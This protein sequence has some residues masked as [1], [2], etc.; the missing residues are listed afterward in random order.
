[1]K[2]QFQDKEFELSDVDHVSANVKI[3]HQ[4]AM[5]CIFEDNE[6]VIK[7]IIKAAVQL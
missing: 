2:S 7:M 6:A 1:M 4:G 5:L 3:S